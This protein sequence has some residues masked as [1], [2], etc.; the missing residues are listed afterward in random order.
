MLCSAR[1]TSLRR[2]TF[3][4]LGWNLFLLAVFSLL[5]LWVVKFEISR[6]LG[7]HR[8]TFPFFIGAWLVASTMAF[9]LA[10][11]HMGDYDPEPMYGGYD[12]CGCQ[13]GTPLPLFSFRWWDPYG[14]A[15]ALR[16]LLFLVM[17]PFSLLHLVATVIFANTR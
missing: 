3:K 16:L 10:R 14:E 4:A 5:L 17:L 1:K 7:D 13:N 8:E 11:I 15:V 12:I 6:L 9:L 2:F